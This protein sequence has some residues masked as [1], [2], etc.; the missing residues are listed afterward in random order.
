[1]RLAATVKLLRKVQ[2][3]EQPRKGPTEGIPL[4][5]AVQL[6]LLPLV[7]HKV[8]QVL[9]GVQPAQPGGWMAWVLA[10]QQ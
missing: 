3:R 8:Q 10:Q 9:H 4:A 5:A 1:M 7:L 2:H 6:L